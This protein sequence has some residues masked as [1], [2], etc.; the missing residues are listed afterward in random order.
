MAP[1]FS[2]NR[3][4]EG[5]THGRCQ[6]DRSI[7]R[8]NH[9][10]AESSTSRRSAFRLPSPIDKSFAVT[11]LIYSSNGVALFERSHQGGGNAYVTR[12][13][14]TSEHGNYDDDDEDDTMTK[15]IAI[16]DPKGSPACPTAAGSNIGR[17][18]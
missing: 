14:P 17:R 10:V 8:S 6:I 13:G 9:H 5:T 3:I 16:H 7:D 4:R 15:I 18:L 12:S 1:H 11:I 2:D